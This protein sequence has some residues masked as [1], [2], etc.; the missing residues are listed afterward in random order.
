MTIGTKAKELF[1]TSYLLFT[2]TLP[3]IPLYARSLFVDPVKHDHGTGDGDVQALR[4]PRHRDDVAPVGPVEQFYGQALFLGAEEQGDLPAEV[5]VTEGE[6]IARRHGGPQLEAGA[7][8]RVGAFGG[9]LMV[10]LYNVPL[11]PS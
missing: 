2:P 7:V 11:H 9:I 10:M 1:G 3:S 6:R 8:E 4:E 5:D